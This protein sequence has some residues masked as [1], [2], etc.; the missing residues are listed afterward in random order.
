[1]LPQRT[2]LAGGMG[3][4]RHTQE[5]MCSLTRVGRYRHADRCR[6]G[7][8]T[9]W[10]SLDITCETWAFQPPVSVSEPFVDVVHRITMQYS[11]RRRLS[12]VRVPTG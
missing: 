10:L 12:S 7:L 5:H 3:R 6:S 1:M 4:V 9:R 11:S 8:H 2:T